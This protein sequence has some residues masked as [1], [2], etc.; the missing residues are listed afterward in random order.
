[1]DAVDSRPAASQPLS[2]FQFHLKSVKPNYFGLQRALKASLTGSIRVLDAVLRLAFGIFEF[3]HRPDC[4]LRV[5]KAS[6][7]EDILLLDGAHIYS[8][9]LILEL[10]FWNEHLCRFQDQQCPESVL[11]FRRRLKD[12]FEMLATYLATT[13]A[14]CRMRA[15]H[16]RLA[17]APGQD[18]ARYT[19]VVQYLGLTVGA[20]P[21]SRFGRFHCSWE[22]LLLYGLRQAFKPY[23]RKRAAL[24]SERLHLWISR[25][26]FLR[27]YFVNKVG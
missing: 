12:S 21:S 1:M 15:L 17:I 7:R 18:V 6:A 8:G 4:I 23:T 26:E 9:D 27:R 25:G 22:N 19:S 3:C 11:G 16:A 2:L 10:H 13:P 20:A 14:M 5:E 24:A